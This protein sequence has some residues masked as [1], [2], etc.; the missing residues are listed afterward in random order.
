[1]FTGPTLSGQADY[2]ST[3]LSTPRRQQLAFEKESSMPYDIE[4]DYYCHYHCETTNLIGPY[5]G[6]RNTGQYS[7]NLI[8]KEY[9]N[10]ESLQN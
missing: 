9:K 1:M 3:N 6:S 2:L 7:I 8:V 5:F 10:T 4:K